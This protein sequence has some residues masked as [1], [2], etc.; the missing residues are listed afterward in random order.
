MDY[1][2]PD[3]LRV[4]AI[5]PFHRGLG[6]AILEGPHRLVDWGIKKATG[7][8]NIECVRIVKDLID[9]Y[10]P[11]VLVLENSAGKRSRRCARVQELL[12]AVR[13][14]TR[15]KGVKV[16]DLTPDSVRRA[17][18]PKKDIV[19]AAIA[20]RFPELAPRL[21][22]PRKCGDSEHSAMPVFDA[23]AFAVTFFYFRNRKRLCEERKAIRAV[24][25]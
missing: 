7:D 14:A 9:Y 19:A 25:G 18:L 1:L 17:F 13:E 10:L 4:L 2:L 8:K 11:H 21:P 3:E 12:R 5:D 22:R 24:L 23:T 20:G 6:F 15:Q 16:M